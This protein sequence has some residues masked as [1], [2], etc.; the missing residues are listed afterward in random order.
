M[1]PEAPYNTTSKH[2]FGL[3]CSENC[4]LGHSALVNNFFGRQF[5]SLND[6]SINPRN[7]DIYFTDTM[8]G[9]WQYFRPEPGLQNQV[10]RFDPDTGAL[11]VVADGFVAPNGEAAGILIIFAWVV[12]DD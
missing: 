9:Y 11:T 8:Y 6:V 2:S 4:L 10:Y 1:N 7:G 5:N 12:A 3:F